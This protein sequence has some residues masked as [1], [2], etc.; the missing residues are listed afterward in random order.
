SFWS[1]LKVNLGCLVES[2]DQLYFPATYKKEED[3]KYSAAKGE[4]EVLVQELSNVPDTMREI[5]YCTKIPVLKIK[6]ILEP[7]P[8]IL[9]L[10]DQNIL[11]SLQKK[12]FNEKDYAEIEKLEAHALD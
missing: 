10:L 4:F 1:G 11:N 3:A 5:I 7:F 12:R 8:K 2:F 9:P 6:K